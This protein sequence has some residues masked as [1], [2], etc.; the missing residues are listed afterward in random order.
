MPVAEP[1]GLTTKNSGRITGSRPPP[2]NR[3]QAKGRIGTEP[4][5]ESA[6]DEGGSIPCVGGGGERRKH[7]AGG[8]I[9]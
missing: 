3:Q 6:N 5:N 7:Q 2:R 1:E 9:R 4:T 8:L